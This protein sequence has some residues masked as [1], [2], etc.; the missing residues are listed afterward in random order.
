M[1]Q[2]TDQLVG[3]ADEVAILDGLVAGLQDGRPRALAVLGSAGIGKSRLLSELARRAEASEHLVL[4]GTAAELEQDLPF[5]PFVNALDD[6]LVA[7]DPQRL[8]RL[9][10]DVR[11]E[12]A[13]VFPALADAAADGA[14]PLQ[15]ERYRS[16]RAVRT[17]L[18]TL[19]TRPLVL[20]LDDFHW[21]DGASVELAGAL[22]RRPP[23]ARVMLVLAARP[24][25]RHQPFDAELTR[26]ERTG[27]LVRLELGPLGAADTRALLGGD[28]PAAL[29]D[30]LHEESGGVPFYIEQLARSATRGS[31]AGVAAGGGDTLVPAPVVA[32]MRDE[33]ALL[34]AGVRRALE[35]A[36]VAGD[37]FEPELA[38]AAAGTSEAEALDALDELLRTDLV[39]PTDQPRRFRFRHPLVRRAVYE[40]S[41]AGWRLGAHERC[42]A[43]LAERGAAVAVR[44]HHVERS[45]R[46]GDAGAADLLREAAEAAAGRAPATA[47]RFYEGALRLLPDSAPAEG[48]VELLLERA[49]ALVAIGRIGDAHAAVVVATELAVAAP[50]PVLVRALLARARMERL[51]G[52]HDETLVHLR[53]ARAIVAPGSP[54]AVALAVEFAL[55][56]PDPA[57]MR[58]WA[59]RAVEEAEALG[60]PPLCA[61]A[62]AALA[63]ASVWW[64]DPAAA[65]RATSAAAEAIDGLGD[66]QLSRRLGAAGTLALAELHRDRFA[67]ASRHAERALTIARRVGDGQLLAPLYAV[68][69]TTLAIEG[70]LQEAWDLLD[71]A[72]EAARLRDDEPGLA[73]VLL[74]RGIV[75]THT[76]ELDA[77]LADVREALEIAGRRKASELG[78]A[79]GLSY[80]IAL[81]ASGDAAGAL[82]TMLD[83]GGGERVD[84]VPGGFRVM[85]LEALTRARIEL[86]LLEDARRTM[87]YAQ[88]VAAHVDQPHAAA[89]AHLARARVELAGGDAEAAG[90]AARTAM[91]DAER[92][93]ALL[94]VAIARTVLGRALVAG[95]DRAG[96]V[97]QLTRAAGELDRMGALGHRAG[98]ERELRRIGE[99]THRRTRAARQGGTGV[100]ALTE[101]EL[102][103]A[104]LTVDRLTNREIAARLFLSEKTI[105]THLRNVFAKLG[106]NSR[107]QVARIVEQAE[108]D[109]PR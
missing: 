16:H 55:W 26:A 66:E 65:D 13:R 28:V 6:F 102:G 46:Q 24:L 85:Y 57:G 33:L 27:G 62:R 104:R 98:A 109:G 59:D 7:L 36:S 5:G 43:L 107:V 80:G 74:N 37:P 60:D 4:A 19:A 50:P 63:L 23:A 1:T 61:S 34:D 92:A 97:E 101:R 21:A 95:G 44:A 90:A 81:L 51:S 31:S 78:V 70:R 71:G 87:D 106:V 11:G 54:D 99:R 38:A 41:P 100:D 3:R 108:R 68:L 47:A 76:G 15:D 56:S 10:D 75:A 103:I 14:K 84:R 25:R 29:A 94:T 48:R 8:S 89:M 52:D 86:G 105:E 18:E 9:G 35:G 83:A 32:A 49:T 12:L 96:A 69:G 20:V 40:A 88:E 22:L 67:D 2:R 58:E 30:T 72:L 39:R 53:A 77:A 42:A 17:L 73:W 91:D 79:A 82:Q 45:A 93:G 64:A